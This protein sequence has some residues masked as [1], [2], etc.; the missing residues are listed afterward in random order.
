[1]LVFDVNESSLF[2]AYLALLFFP[3]FLDGF[4]QELVLPDF[5]DELSFGILLESTRY[6]WLID[7]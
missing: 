7:S 6:I 3:S 2:F 4:V 1:M 5:N